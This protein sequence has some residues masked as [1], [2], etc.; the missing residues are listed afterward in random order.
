[1]STIKREEHDD[2]ATVFVNPVEI[3]PE[4]VSSIG[5]KRSYEIKYEDTSD[6]ESRFSHGCT[7]Y[8]DEPVEIKTQIDIDAAKAKN[9][10]ETRDTLRK[11]GDRV[12]LAWQSFV[13]R[14]DGTREKKGMLALGGGNQTGLLWYKNEKDRSNPAVFHGDFKLCYALALHES[15]NW[16]V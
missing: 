10:K 4:Q 13:D 7:A 11:Y 12:L 8:D 14:P 15:W 2:E 1:M 9:A 16:Y 6:D 3:K 5:R